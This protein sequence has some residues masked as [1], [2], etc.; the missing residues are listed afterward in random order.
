MLKVTKSSLL[1]GEGNCKAYNTSLFFCETE[2][3]F[4]KFFHL[5][6]I[7]GVHYKL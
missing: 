5:T 4:I 1:S 2:R 6:M 7:G 3:N